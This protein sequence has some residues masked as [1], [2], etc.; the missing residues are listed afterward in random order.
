MCEKCEELRKR[1]L[2][3]DEEGIRRLGGDEVLDIR[4]RMLKD[5]TLGPFGS[6]YQPVDWNAT[7]TKDDRVRHTKRALDAM[8]TGTLD[9]SLM[10]RENNGEPSGDGAFNVICGFVGRTSPTAANRPSLRFFD[11]PYLV[12][13]T[14]WRFRFA[15]TRLDVTRHL[16]CY[17]MTTQAVARILGPAALDSARLMHSSTGRMVEA[18][19]MAAVM[20]DALKQGAPLTQFPDGSRK[21]TPPVS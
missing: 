5:D 21:P 14:L 3:G 13:L 11:G 15:I 10:M 20:A 12:S 2:N 16:E 9:V 6:S 4:A 1:I 8:L 7:M 19:E 17:A 18:S